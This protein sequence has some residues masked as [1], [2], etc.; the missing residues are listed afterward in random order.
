MIGV[1]LDNQGPEVVKRFMADFRMTYCVVLG[2]VMLMQAFG[3]TAIPT[4]VV[5]NRAGHI[6]ARHVGFTPR[7]TFENEIQPLL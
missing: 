7:E 6:V 5:I 4:T 2:D 3:G 1:S